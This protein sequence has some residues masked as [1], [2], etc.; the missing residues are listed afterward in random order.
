LAREAGRARARTQE[1]YVVSLS[2]RRAS[3]Q[4]TKPGLHA[5]IYR[6]GLYAKHVASNRYTGFKPFS[7]QTFASNSELK[8]KVIKF[9][10]REVCHL[11]PLG[12]IPTLLDDSN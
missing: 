11:A 12:L 6:E 10:R 5:D 2:S 3:F 7:P 4:L 1:V 9:I 8:A